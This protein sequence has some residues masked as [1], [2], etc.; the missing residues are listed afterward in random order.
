MSAR[1]PQRGFV[2]VGVVMLV[3]ALTILGITLYGL[4]SYEAVFLQQTHDENAA[5]YRAQGGIAMV[6]ALVAKND[7]LDNA[8]QAVGVDGVTAAV[9]SQRSLVAPYNLVSTGT[10]RTGFSDTVYVSVTAGQGAESRTVTAR[11]LPQSTDNFYKRLFT[12]GGNI[13]AIK[14]AGGHDR[15]NT[16][17]L[18]GDIW[19]QGNRLNWGAAQVTWA[20]GSLRTEPVPP[21]DAGQFIT[22]HLGEATNVVVTSTVTEDNL[23]LTAPLGSPSFYTVTSPAGTDANFDFNENKRLNVHVTGTVV[24]LLQNGANIPLQFFVD[25]S[26]QADDC[27]IL[28]AN[29]KGANPKGIAFS[30]GMQVTG[31]CPMILASDGDIDLDA[32]QGYLQNDNFAFNLSVY[33]RNLEMTGPWESNPSPPPAHPHFN[34]AYNAAVMNP[35]ID[36]IQARCLPRPQG[37]ASDKFALVPGS[38]RDLTP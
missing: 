24:W 4:S 31:A 6:L 5:L 25:H 16:I 11:Y 26:G 12:V 9:A 34:M 7:S 19:L 3:L 14:D 2:L 22:D 32:D 37:A 15:E 20:S 36:A 8:A 28:V 35:L 1:A 17:I 27:L 38:W 13:T 10:M 33:C 30:G 23:S 29:R 18:N 21:P